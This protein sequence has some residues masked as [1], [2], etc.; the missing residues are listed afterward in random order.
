MPA[1]K[2]LLALTV[3][4]ALVLAG[5]ADTGPRQQAGAFT[6]AALGGLIGATRPG[7]NL[8]TAAVGAAIGGLA[9]GAIGAA[10]DKQAG[11]LRAA[12]PSSGIKV[13]NTGSALLVTMP[14]DI[15]F[16]T[17]SAAVRAALYPDLQALA[18]HLQRYPNSTIQVIGHTDNVGSAAY[19]LD[20]SQRR[21]AAVAAII[22]ANGVSPVRV[23]TL[24]KGEDAPIASNLTPEGRQQNRRVEI[25]IYPNQ[26]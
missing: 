3:S 15:L 24:G 5:C 20:L 4:S 18:A 16:D 23:S 11:D 14:N 12:L 19:N 6:G 17:D 1:T 21:A 8:G 13:V 2:P 10:L 9:G 22:T 7:G 26:T 25:Y